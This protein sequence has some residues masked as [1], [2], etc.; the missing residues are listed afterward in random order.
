MN[1]SSLN[2]SVLVHFV[3]IILKPR[4]G[5]KGK[6]EKTQQPKNSCVYYDPLKLIPLSQ[7]MSSIQH[8]TQTNLQTSVSTS[9]HSLLPLITSNTDKIKDR[10]LNSKGRKLRLNAI[11]RWRR[12]WGRHDQSPRGPMTE[13]AVHTEEYQHHFGSLDD[14]PYFFHESSSQSPLI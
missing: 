12:C 13:E 9:L 14:Y 1:I 7:F 10:Y 5:Q 6:K 3:P 4:S 2:Y 11:V 8:D